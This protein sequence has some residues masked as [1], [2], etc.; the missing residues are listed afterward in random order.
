MF[1]YL[2][3][4][5]ITFVDL[6]IVIDANK[7]KQRSVK[8]LVCSLEE[9]FAKTEVQEKNAPEQRIAIKT[10]RKSRAMESIETE[11]PTKKNN[12]FE[13]TA[14]GQRKWQ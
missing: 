14:G 6:N 5:E 10:N 7:A 9:K 13:Q 1:Q 3:S 4:V 11:Q 8:K 2:H 12:S